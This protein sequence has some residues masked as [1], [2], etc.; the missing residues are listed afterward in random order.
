MNYPLMSGL[1]DAM[2]TI[3]F[4]SRIITPMFIAGADGRTP[5]LRAPGVKAALRFWW[6]AINGH[7]SIK[8]LRKKEA[9]IFGGTDNGGKSN[10][11]L[12]VLDQPEKNDII[13]AA[14][15]PHK[16]RFTKPAIRPGFEFDIKIRVRAS[17][18]FS[19]EDAKFSLEDAKHLFTLVSFLGGLGSRSRRGFGSFAIEKV[20]GLVFNNPETL[21]DIHRIIEKL[22]NRFKIKNN[23]IISNFGRIENYPFI[24]EIDLGRPDNRLLDKISYATHE[25]KKLDRIAYEASLGHAYNGRF[26]SP[27]YVSVVKGKRPVI[28]TLNT[29]PDKKNKY[30]YVRS[31]QE[32]FKHRIL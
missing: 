31:I 4:K 1:N 22:N 9:E 20:D 11:I 3:T 30:N 27:V 24:R 8:D 23:Q 25:V 7:F 18:I 29:V 26:A 2:D 15:T 21:N 5:E 17:N 13:A 6:R 12:R 28:T 10:V 14:P 19:L 32:E 16:P